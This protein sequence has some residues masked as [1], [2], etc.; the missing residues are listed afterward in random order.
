MCQSVLAI[1]SNAPQM[2]NVTKV[3]KMTTKVN[4]QPM[5]KLPAHRDETVIKSAATAK[6]AVAP[7]MFLHRLRM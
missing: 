6:L 4:T 7:D 3:A 1:A 2:G 5:I